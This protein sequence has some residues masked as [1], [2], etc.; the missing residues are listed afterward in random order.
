MELKEFFKSFFGGSKHI[1]EEIEK[2]TADLKP[3]NNKKKKPIEPKQSY[4]KDGNL[5]IQS[6]INDEI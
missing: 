6:K 4:D 3:L 1:M 5:I 2:E